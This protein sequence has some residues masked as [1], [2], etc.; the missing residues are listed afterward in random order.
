MVTYLVTLILLL[1]K[2]DCRVCF[3]GPRRHFHAFEA[4][5]N[6]PW[7]CRFDTDSFKI[8]V[9]NFASRC[10]ANNKAYFE[11]LI[12][13]T[14]RKQ[15]VQGISKGLEIVG[16]GTF[17]FDIEDDDGGLHTIKIKNSVCT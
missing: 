10:M 2:V 13:S 15:S 1:L 12:L 17:V 14:E 6:I 7:S 11:A 4:I 9:D 5:K 8:G 3:D 16:K